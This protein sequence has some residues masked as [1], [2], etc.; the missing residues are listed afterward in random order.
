MF[1]GP[2]GHAAKAALNHAAVKDPL[3]KQDSYAQLSEGNREYW[4]RRGLQ[5]AR[6]TRTPL[7]RG[8]LCSGLDLETP[9]RALGTRWV[10]S[11]AL[12]VARGGV[13]D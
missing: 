4:V 10:V 9:A 7:A 2:H 6:P 1:S 12:L 5:G 11:S 3:A 8:S 13:D